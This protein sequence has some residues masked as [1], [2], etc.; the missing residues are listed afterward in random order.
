MFQD[1]F[2]AQQINGQIAATLRKLK[3]HIG[4]KRQKTNFVTFEMHISK[5]NECFPGY[6][7]VAQVPKRG[8]CDTRGEIDYN[9]IFEEIKSIDSSWIIGAEYL[10][11]N[12]SKES[13][14]WVENMSLSF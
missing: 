13:F 8:A 14:N 12:S 10:D 3:E 9:F 11:E 1:T 5:R 4:K 6:I 7:Q 2:H